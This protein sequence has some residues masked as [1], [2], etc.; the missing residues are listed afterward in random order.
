MIV[1]ANYC[2]KCGNKLNGNEIYCIKCGHKIA[3]NNMIKKNNGATI[4]G[5]VLSLISVITC[6]LTSIIGLIL[7][8]IGLISSK[9]KNRKDG[10][11]VAG[12]I[13]ST[14][15]LLYIS[16][17]VAIEMINAEELVVEDFSKM[18]Y[19]EAVDYCKDSELT[20]YVI[21]KYSDTIPEGEFIS[22]DEEAGKEIKSYMGVH[23]YYSKGQ[24]SKKKQSS[25][26]NTD[27]KDESSNNDSDNDKNYSNLK[28]ISDQKLKNNFIDSCEKINMDVSEIRNLEKV[29]D[30]NSGPRYT[31]SYK[32]QTF[33]LYA[34]DNGDVSS[35]TIANNYLD[36]IYLDGY[37]PVDVNDFIFDSSKKLTLQVAAEDRIK[38]VLKY[39]S[40]AK[41][42]WLGYGYARR[43]DIY[44]ITGT[45]RAKNAMG[46]EIDHK[47]VIEF[48]VSG[49]DYSTVYLNINGE[50]LLGSGSQL[51]DITRKE[52][53]TEETNSGDGSFVIKEGTL[54]TYG[55]KDLFDGEEYIRYYIPAGTYEVEAL[56]KNA[57]FYIETIE[58]HKEDGYDASTFIRTVKLE[59]VGDK[60]TITVEK[61]QCISLVV[62]TQIK[63]KKTN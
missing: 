22:Q 27:K 14:I 50:K 51:K 38:L 30:W 13:I 10:L 15:M 47:F 26:N 42:D 40:T 44:Q 18:T 63:L 59:K 24:K 2:I 5:F 45:F 23:V 49:E 43:Y 19:K 20:C 58:I 17:S 53:Q 35:I 31:F 52:L 4:A 41:F 36:K 39:P 57:M 56:T 33:I 6:G 61:D 28:E 55:K 37:E 48:K 3:S 60:E 54:G 32:E 21:E 11:A 34:L 7:S 16:I 25:K 12:I 1:M 9:K 46:V 62:Y 29:D 8:I